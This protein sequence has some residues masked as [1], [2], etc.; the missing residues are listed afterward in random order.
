MAAPPPG[1]GRLRKEQVR[2]LALEGGGGKGFAFVGA[3]AA[4]EDPL[5][6]L[7]YARV[8]PSPNAKVFKPDWLPA[9]VDQSR[10]LT[11][12][13]RGVAGASAGAITALMLSCGYAAA[14]IVD[15][16]D[17][18]DFD[19]F[20]EP[21]DPRMVPKLF[22]TA[23]ETGDPTGGEVRQAAPPSEGKGDAVA[24]KAT[25]VKALI[26]ALAP[27]LG[28]TIDAAKLGGAALAMLWNRILRVL[29]ELL[30]IYADLNG[31]TGVKPVK[32]LLQ[33]L[34]KYLEY[35]PEDMGLFPGYQAR[36]FLAELLAAK[37]PSLDG[38]PN[39]NVSFQ[40]HFDFFG[41]KLVV[42][43]T[44]LETGKSEIFSVD[45]T[46]NFPVADAVR[47][48]M[49]LP[50]VFKPLV[51]RESQIAATDR[52]YA[53]VWVD[54]GLFNNLPITAFDREKKAADGPDTLGLRLE[55]DKVQPIESFGDLLRVWPLG[56]G[57][58]GTGES[59][60]SDS[61]GNTAQTIALDTEGLSLLN[62][63]PDPKLRQGAVDRARQ[64]TL[65]YFAG[66]IEM[67]PEK[68]TVR[69]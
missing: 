38:K 53:G 33:H 21:P 62:F 2:Y 65:D 29:P 51:I 36:T 40:T 67:R 41:I 5:G 17:A 15:I 45:T 63:K 16:M 25:A 32:M 30:Q 54:G 64:K 3:V 47:I 35:L 8:P 50:L 20:F 14:E 61:W 24:L 43:G 39:F 69:R 59:A 6:L 26:R 42:T 22:L 9:S 18:Y 27:Q 55:E 7:A 58:G 28:V 60:I 57:I 23:R 52:S 31:I 12:Q 46:P 49:G 4:L 66:V 44:N 10:R 37:F 56:L 68:L 34:P 11:G 19:R 1:N 13:I 48:S